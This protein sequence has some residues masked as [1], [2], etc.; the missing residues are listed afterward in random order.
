MKAISV[1]RKICV[2]LLIITP[3]IFMAGCSK[4]FDTPPVEIPRFSLPAGD[5][6]ITIKELKA[7]H[8]TLGALDTIKHPYYVTGIVVSSD[9]SGNIYKSLYIQDTS[10]GLLIS[11]DATSLYNLYP[12][13]Q[14]VY[15]KCKDL[16][17][18]DYNGMPQ[19]GVNYNGSIGR[20][21]DPLI[22][23][24][25]L[26]D[27]LPG[28]LPAPKVITLPIG[29]DFNLG[30]LVKLVD[31]SFVDVGLPYSDAA[32]TTNR[33]IT[34]GVNNLL[35]RTSNYATFRAELIPDGTGSVTGIL[36]LFGSDFQLYIRDL[37]DV[38][39]FDH[40]TTLL[41][42]EPFTSGIGAFTAYS[43]S[44]AQAW[45]FSTTYGMT[46]SGFSGSVNNVNEDWLISPAIDLT[47][48]NNVSIMF[49]HTINK[50]VVAN[51]AANHNLWVTKNYVAGSAP[52][53]ATWEQVTIPTY[54]NGAN[55]TFVSSGP[56]LL[57]VGYAGNA[58]VRFAYKYQSSATESATWEIKSVLVKGVHN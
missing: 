5:T 27:S 38:T 26:I 11:L 10:G 4:K 51:M 7:F 48:Y 35:M 13:G 19:L 30:C 20:I 6:L 16:I 44:G 23:S 22:T 50:G 41:L 47:Q 53:T 54:P 34:D 37:N 31:V 45:T 43:V 42:N 36:G 40:S 55:W 57:P 21:P 3:G 52:S 12:L 33:T 15:V 9:E 2:L 18:G 49:S 8:A 46:M 1:I 17:M 29:N 39:G 58:N 56:A 32:A 14:R 24:I 28:P 25:L